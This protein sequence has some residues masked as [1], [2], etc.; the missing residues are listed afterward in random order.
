MFFHIVMLLSLLFVPSDF[1]AEVEGGREG[2]RGGREDLGNFMAVECRGGGVSSSWLQG[3]GGQPQ[4]LVTADRH[5]A[6]RPLAK[7]DFWVRV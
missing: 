7:D 5:A 3:A 2:G 6:G 4:F 1:F